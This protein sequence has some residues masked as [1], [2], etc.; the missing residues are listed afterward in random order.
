MCE[1]KL[2]RT[3]TKG[4]YFKFENQ[5]TLVQVG[6]QQA[7]TDVKTGGNENWLKLY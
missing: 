2:Y 7:R 6:G 4:R 5:G 3:L 1:R